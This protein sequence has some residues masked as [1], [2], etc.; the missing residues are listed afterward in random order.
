M[1]TLARRGGVIGGASMTLSGCPTRPAAL[2]E[3]PK[4]GGPSV[5]RRDVFDTLADENVAS[6]E[7]I[8]RL[9]EFKDWI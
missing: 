7:I 8:G 3:R 6:M 4:D 9:T 2:G 1:K 5:P